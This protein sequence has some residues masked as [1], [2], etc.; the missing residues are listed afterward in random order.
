LIQRAYVDSSIYALWPSC[1]EMK[2]GL[3][4]DIKQ[5]VA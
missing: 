3:M 1:C 5:I 2:A 4:P